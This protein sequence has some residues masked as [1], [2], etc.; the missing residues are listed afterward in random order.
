MSMHEINFGKAPQMIQLAKSIL[1]VQ[2]SEIAQMYLWLS[3]LTET[4]I[5]TTAAYSLA[6]SQ[7]MQVKMDNM[8]SITSLTDLD[9]A[10]ARIL[11]PHHQGVVDMARLIIQYSGDS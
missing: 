3:A 2:Q 9:N 10:F 11:T 6:M 8:L 7:N 5:V 4:R 1:I